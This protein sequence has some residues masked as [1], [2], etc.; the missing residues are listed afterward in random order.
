MGD[1]E[2][3]FPQL[4]GQQVEPR[5]HVRPQ[6]GSL[7]GNGPWTQEENLESGDRLWSKKSWTCYLHTVGDQMGGEIQLHERLPNSCHRENAHHLAERLLGAVQIVGPDL[8]VDYL[9]DK[10]GS[11]NVICTRREGM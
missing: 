4:S 10:A 1:G 11:E 2:H 7:P 8:L 9:E 6:L 3:P 5:G